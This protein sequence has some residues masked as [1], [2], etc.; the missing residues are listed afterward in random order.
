M[1][2]TY[3]Q[4]FLYVP[5]GSTEKAFELVI[6][7]PTITD[8]VVKETRKFF[9]GCDSVNVQIKLPDDEIGSIVLWGDVLKNSYLVIK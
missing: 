6:A 2:K 4:I 8:D 5:S 1:N 9:S 3:T 7:Q